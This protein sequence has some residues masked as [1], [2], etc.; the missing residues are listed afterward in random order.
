MR[1]GTCSEVVRVPDRKAAGVGCESLGAGGGQHRLLEIGGPAVRQDRHQRG[2]RP[3]AR[4]RR[5]SD[6]GARK[7]RQAADVQKV[8]GR[9]RLPRQRHD[10]AR[11]P[12]R[13]IGDEAVREE[14]QRLAAVDPAQGLEAPGDT[15]E[16]RLHA[17]PPRGV[18]LHRTAAHHRLAGGALADH[19]PFIAL[20]HALAHA[21]RARRQRVGAARGPPGAARRLCRPALFERRRVLVVGDPEGL[22]LGHLV[23]RGSA[24]RTCRGRARRR[25][26]GPRAPP[27]CARSTRRRRS[28]CPRSPHPRHARRSRGTPGPS[29]V[30]PRSAPAPC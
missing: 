5:R 7:R 29:G 28:S 3:R 14:Q 20:A 12:V 10:L 13:R 6:A 17:G 2:A 25:P 23:G 11:A 19:L 27:G 24:P 22:V 9:V 21:A 1:R 16:R 26:A 4:I 15:G 8:D 30:R 18:Q